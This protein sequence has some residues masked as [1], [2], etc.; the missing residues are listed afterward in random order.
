MGRFSS[1]GG[2]NE[3][4]GRKRGSKDRLKVSTNL[5]LASQECHPDRVPSHLTKLR[6]DAQERFKQIN[7]AYQVLGD[8]EKR[9]QY[10]E[11]L[12]ELREWASRPSA[13]SHSNHPPP[14]PPPPK[15]PEG[16]S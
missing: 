12:K 2:Q 13:T 10:D 8:P 11:H 5:S 1:P 4:R 3:A 7:E 15:P 16:K 14:K 9:R 6:E